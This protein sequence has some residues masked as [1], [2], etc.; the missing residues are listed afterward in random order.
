MRTFRISLIA[1]IA[2]SVCIV[3]M[4]N[5]AF[6]GSLPW[7][8][9]SMDFITGSDTEVEYNERGYVILIKSKNL[10]PNY[11]FEAGT[12]ED[13]D[14]WTEAGDADRASDKVHS[15]GWSL[16]SICVNSNASS[17]NGPFTV[18]PGHTYKFGVWI[19]RDSGFAGSTS[20]D[21]SDLP[22]GDPTAVVSASGAW[23]YGYVNWQNP[24]YTSVTVR[25]V[26]DGTSNGKVWFDDLELIDL[27][28]ASGATYGLYT[29][30]LLECDTDVTFGKLSWIA[31]IPEGCTIAFLTASAS[32]PDGLNASLDTV[33]TA[34]TNSGECE[35]KSP[36]NKYFQFRAILKSVSG[37]ITPVLKK[38]TVTSAVKAINTEV[39]AERSYKAVL[40]PGELV[41]FKIHFNIPMSTDPADSCAVTIVP[42]SGTPL[43]LNGSGIW[44]DS[45]TFETNNTETLGSMG[46]GFATVAVS[47]GKTTTYSH[48][49]RQ[50]YSSF[51]LFAT[52][53]K[54]TVDRFNLFP[55]PFS[56]NGD[57]RND[58]ASLMFTA[59]TDPTDVTVKIFDLKGKL[60][61]TLFSR[62]AVIGDQ[63]VAWDGRDEKGQICPVG[64][65]VIQL[66][67]G[68]VAKNGTITLAK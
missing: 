1:G 22:T 10:I 46:G 4:V 26:T 61:K 58:E 50:T 20:I 18:T 68:N 13:A 6:A 39:G 51:I 33:A 28:E 8:Q 14:N 17:T 16:K 43:T 23:T 21:M 60:M 36:P 54:A 37:K 30:N 15:G 5:I 7:V 34:V 52:D 40:V 12:N 9:E 24:S 56:P 29:S 65:Y 2:I 64:V 38:V 59:G 31:D 62:Q 44:T 67:K 42:V 49:I 53:E 45:Y 48:P 66:K 57:G 25:A 63:T 41:N 3:N 35:I 47:G 32:S 27:T 19:F 11:S 55:N